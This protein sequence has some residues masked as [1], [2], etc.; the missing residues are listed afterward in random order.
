MKILLFSQSYLP[1]ATAA[2][3]RAA[4]N[5]AKWTEQGHSVTVFT[6]YPNYPV[7]HI[8]GGYH[9]KLLLKEEFNGVTIFRNK[10]IPKDNKTF[11]N[12]IV[13]ASSFFFFGLFNLVFNRKKLKGNYDVVIG[14]SG[15]V[16]AALLGWIYAFTSNISFVLEVRD[17]TYRQLIAT[18]RN[19]GSLSVRAMRG[20]EL[21]LCKRA[22][23]VI[24]V[25]NGF[26]DVFICDG[27]SGEKIEVITNGVDL[28]PTAQ[29]RTPG[30][31]FVLSYFGTLGISQ[32]IEDAFPYA[33]FMSQK[34][35]LFQFLIIGEGAQRESIEQ[36]VKTGRYP[37]I[38]L[39]HGM[40]QQELESFYEKT[41]LSVV[42]LRKSSDFK[43]TLPSKLFQIMGRGIAVLFIGP[44]GEAAQIVRKYDA[45]LT[46]CGTVEEDMARLKE[47]FST[48]DWK[49]QLHRMGENG[50]QAVREHYS[51]K[52]LAK[53]YA[54]ILESLIV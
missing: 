30:I 20:L 47:F 21:F 19:E 34:V 52:K 12:R 48:P 6:A 17:I 18:G 53:E 38:E 33:D 36:D 16:F 11:F 35:E 25:T 7:G 4:E 24:V 23:K 15:T 46:L 22:K 5:A 27:I 45:G 10:L 8:F 44:E 3:F 29:M 9:P 1:E 51:R 31:P 54:D 26:K 32:N 49:Q 39:L 2:A 42:T 13:N 28:L 14:T 40:P 50:M 41:E 43:F 37:F